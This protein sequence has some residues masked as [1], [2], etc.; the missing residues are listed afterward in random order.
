VIDAVVRLLPGVLGAEASMVEESHSAGLLEYPH[1][2]R[3]ADFQGWS[4]PEILL[5]GNHAAI[6]R[7]RRER[8]EEL[9]RARRPELLRP[10]HPLPPDHEGSR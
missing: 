2:T 8:A 1:Y 5:S 6:A 9:T 7:W 4:V 10:A 3:P